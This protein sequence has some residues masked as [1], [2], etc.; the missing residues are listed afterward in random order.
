M[1]L[2][3]D[4]DDGKISHIDE[5][6]R[7]YSTMA[8]VDGQ[9]RL[10]TMVLLLDAIRRDMA[11]IASLAR[12]AEGIRKSYI[13]VADQGG[14]AIYK[15]LLHHDSRDFF[16]RNVLSD[17]PGPDGPSI[18]SHQQLYDAWQFFAEYLSGQQNQRG[19]GYKD[20]LVSLRNKVVQHL[21]VTIYTV[22]EQEEV[23]VIFETLNNRGKPL[24]ELEKVKNYLLYLASK[25]DV[26][27]HQL[28]EEV[29]RAWTHI[30]KRLMKAHMASSE[31]EDR[32][33]RSHWL[34]AY[35]SQQRNWKGSKSIKA[36]FN[37]KDYQS[38][39]KELLQDLHE[40]TSFLQDA[41]LAYC[42][43]YK[44]TRTSAFAGFTQDSSLHKQ[45]AYRWVSGWFVD[46]KL[47]E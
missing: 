40:Y 1:V 33:L 19:P 14:Q 18:Q 12:L 3:E 25:L 9:Q 32:L 20:Y 23:G 8:V 31:D 37:L 35:D 36:Q 6:G 29:N 46:S 26:P 5:E 43:A 41:S 34:M 24:S 27:R 21:K 44:P 10:T 13:A 17:S 30:F 42:D 47:P 11:Q 15:L 28:A 38:C 4:A 16:I 39:H 22:E 7:H 2:H 45:T